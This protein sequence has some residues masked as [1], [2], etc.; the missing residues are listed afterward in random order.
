MG[1]A[2]RSDEAAARADVAHLI[3][4][5]EQLARLPTPLNVVGW[6]FPVELDSSW[7]GAAQLAPLL[8]RLPRP[9]WL[10]VYDSANVG[11]GTLADWLEGWLPADI[12]IFFQDS[13]GVHARS[14]AVAREHVQVLRRRLGRQRVRLIAEAFRPRVGGGFRPAAADE[15][16]AQRQSYRGLPVYL[17]DAPHYQSEA[18]IHELVCSR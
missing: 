5:S 1:L 8:A 6:Y 4:V 16:R 11:A 9:L 12:G 15:L 3:A 18:L 10:S 7:Q 13:V 17:F 2:G 14:A